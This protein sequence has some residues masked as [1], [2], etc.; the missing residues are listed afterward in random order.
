MKVMNILH[1]SVVDG[2]GL[3]TVVFFA[4][5]PHQCIGCH[6]PDSWKMSNGREMSVDEILL[7]LEG[8]PLTDITFSG[9]EPLIQAKKLVELAKELK[10]LNKNIWLY[11]GFTYEEIMNSRDSYKKEVLTYCDVLVDG[12]FLMEER[13]LSLMFK[14]SRNQ[15][16]IYL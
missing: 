10:G 4:G 11:S 14:G 13:D 15:R 3:R 6:N 7:E 8:N 12:R 5:C 9:G 16:I 2:E 1:D